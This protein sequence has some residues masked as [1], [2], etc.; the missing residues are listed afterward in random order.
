MIF[1]QVILQ[2]SSINVESDVEVDNPAA[3]GESTSQLSSSDSAVLRS[4]GDDIVLKPPGDLAPEVDLGD[5]GD[6]S[7]PSSGDL[8]QAKLMTCALEFFSKQTMM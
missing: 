4:S 5:E 6:S 1:F 7:L 8:K 2:A 3:V